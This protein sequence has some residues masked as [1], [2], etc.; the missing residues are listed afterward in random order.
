MV[1]CWE[2]YL[3]LSLTV[4]L[5]HGT[6]SSKEY[7][8]NENWQLKTNE[9]SKLK[10]CS[11]QRKKE[12]EATRTMH[13]KVFRCHGPRA[14]LVCKI[15]YVVFQCAYPPVIVKENPGVPWWGVCVGT[16]GRCSRSAVTR[17]GCWSW[18][19]YQK[20]PQGLPSERKRKI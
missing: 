15:S 8:E 4:F 6:F 5:L 16:S 12:T 17:S 20:G 14:F 3:L 19:F 13:P 2:S 7:K 1:L 11:V 18:R 9:Q 10:Q